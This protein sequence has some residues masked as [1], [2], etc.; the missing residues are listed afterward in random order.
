MPPY[1]IFKQSILKQYRMAYI[2]R[3]MGRTN[4]SDYQKFV[5]GKKELMIINVSPRIQYGWVDDY[6]TALS[7]QPV[8]FDLSIV[9]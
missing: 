5:M 8:T 1:S 7:V 4:P 9:A 6:R 3:S 2:Q